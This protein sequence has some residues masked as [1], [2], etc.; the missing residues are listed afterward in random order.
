[1]FSL[2]KE[3]AAFLEGR[4][5]DAV[6]FRDEQWIRKLAFLTDITAHLN[7]LNLKLQGSNQLIN[8]LYQHIVA[9]E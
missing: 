9:F 6:E 8:E 1:M 2:R 7:N 4:N 3:I 5:V